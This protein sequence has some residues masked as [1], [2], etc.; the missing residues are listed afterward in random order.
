MQ[1]CSGGHG[2]GADVGSDSVG[3]VNSPP[4]ALRPVPEGLTHRDHQLQV[5]P[6]VA[7]DSGLGWLVRSS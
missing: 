1:G 7:L 3:A 4:R 2:A 6:R 5:M